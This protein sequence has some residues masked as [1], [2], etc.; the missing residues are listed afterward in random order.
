MPDSFVEPHLDFARH[1]LGKAAVGPL[2][3]LVVEESEGP[4]QVETCCFAPR[5]S[6]AGVQGACLLL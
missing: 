1:R 3:C 2:L 6:W 4:G 5:L